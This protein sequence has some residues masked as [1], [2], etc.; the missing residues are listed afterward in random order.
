MMRA[1]ALLLLAMPALCRA[2]D[3]LAVQLNKQIMKCWSPS[4]A[5]KDATRPE[6][7]IV[8][9]EIALNLDGSIAQPPQLSANPSLAAG[10]P[11]ARA[12]AEAARRAIWACAPYTMPPNRYEQWREV[13]LSFDASHLL[14]K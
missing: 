4:A 14:T 13:V 5:F 10:D 7:L 9:Y 1:V 3:D 11:V 12:A 8:Q 6:Q 2:D